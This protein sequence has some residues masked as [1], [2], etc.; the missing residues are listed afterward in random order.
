MT[1]FLGGAPGAGDKTT[2]NRLPRHLS[3]VLLQTID[4]TTVSAVALCLMAAGYRYLP[5]GPPRVSHMQ[6]A[7]S[8][9]KI[10]PAKGSARSRKPGRTSFDKSGRGIW[11]WQ[12]ATG[13][14]EQHITDEQLAELE[15]SQLTFLND[16][17]KEAGAVSY[18]EFREQTKSKAPAASAVKATGTSPGPITRLF[19][20]FSRKV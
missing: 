4:L 17:V 8:K 15:D 16:N 6:K 13:V 1:L 10:A 7:P 9:S 12:T 3:A 18:F 14:F 5:L 19:S 20:R 11:E 2:I